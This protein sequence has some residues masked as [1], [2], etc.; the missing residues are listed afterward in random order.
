V[1]DGGLTDV[2][3]ESTVLDLTAEIPTVL[4]PGGVTIEEL[5]AVIGAVRLDPRANAVAL[6]VDQGGPVRSPGM[7]YKHYAPVAPTTLVEGEP[8]HIWPA[9]WQMVQTAD[10]S[11]PVGLV[12]TTEGKLW[13]DENHKVAVDTGAVIVEVV[14]SRTD[15][16]AIAR[17]VFSSLRVMDTAGVQQIIIEGLPAQGLGLAIMNRLRRAAGGCIYQAGGAT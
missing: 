17:H 10:A 9:I 1:R 11:S 15:P 7:K 3:L 2:G 12:L 16:A 13:L 5:S 4:R 8:S 14:G 6:S